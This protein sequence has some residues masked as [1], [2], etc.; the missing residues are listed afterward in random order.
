MLFLS[1]S[2]HFPHRGFY[3]DGVTE[4]ALISV[5]LL[6]CHVTILRWIWD[7]A[8]GYFCLFIYL[9]IDIWLVSR[10]QRKL[11]ACKQSCYGNPHANL[12]MNLTLSFFSWVTP[13]VGWLGHMV[14]VSLFK[15]IA[16]LLPKE[17]VP[18]FIS[19]SNVWEFQFLHLFK[20]VNRFCRCVAIL[21][22]GFNERFPDD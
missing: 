10:L 22:R 21:L 12:C 19:I 18:F 5:W 4:D 3:A 15:E 1:I 6:W 11:P 17:D 2:I 7:S 13:A 8:W 20:N 14:G 9:L 16:E